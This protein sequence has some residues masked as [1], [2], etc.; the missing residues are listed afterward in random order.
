MAQKLPLSALDACFDDA[1]I[2]RHVPEVIA[3]LDTLEAQVRG[4]ASARPAAREVAHAP[5]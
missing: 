5:R 1:A 2:L 3:R 4:R